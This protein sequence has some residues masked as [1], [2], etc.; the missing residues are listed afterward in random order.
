M[1]VSEAR[2]EGA[3]RKAR[4][5]KAW[6]ADKAWAASEAGT[7]EART[8]EARTSEAS[9]WADGGVPATKRAASIP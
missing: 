3:M 6:A 5:G 9:T 4:A 2:S 1:E 8:S 7:S